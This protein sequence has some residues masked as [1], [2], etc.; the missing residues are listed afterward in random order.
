MDSVS[1]M[2]RIIREQ[3]DAA[4]YLQDPVAVA[5]YARRNGCTEKQACDGARQGVYDWVMEE[6]LLWRE[7][8]RG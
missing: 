3:A 8:I 6:I 7:I 1:N 5:D 2:V 4:H